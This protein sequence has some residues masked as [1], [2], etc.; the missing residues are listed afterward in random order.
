MGGLRLAHARAELILD[1]QP[2]SCPGHAA[3]ALL[4][5]PADRAADGIGVE[6]LHREQRAEHV[7][8]GGEDLDPGGDPAAEALARVVHAHGLEQPRVARPVPDL[9][10]ERVEQ[11]GP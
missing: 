4:L 7:T 9:G 5:D 3:G 10:R 2:P 8:V 11:P 6:L 1:T